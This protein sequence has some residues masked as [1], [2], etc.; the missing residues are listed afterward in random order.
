MLAQAGA[1]LRETTAL[2]TGDGTIPVDDTPVAEVLAGPDG[3]TRA[4]GIL[5]A[6]IEA[7]DS[8]LRR[9]ID[10]AAADA[11]LREV[12]GASQTDEEGSGAGIAAALAW[13]AARIAALVTG[14]GGVPDLRFLPQVLI[15]LGLALVAFILA[16]LGRGLKERFRREVL[17]ADHARER[18]EDPAVHLRAAESAL[19]GGRARDAIH[20]LYL[21]VI[22]SLSARELIRYD[23]A[24]TDRELLQRAAAIPQ[25]D[26]LRELIALN[27]R[28]WFGLRDPDPNEAER[29]RSL[30]ARV[31]G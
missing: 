27:E 8:A 18:A 20:E 11:R 30:A 25:A 12:L 31:A 21:F 2:R 7:A 5:D 14:L 1:L 22:G 16:T 24:L 15:G 17:V 4:L 28:A 19:A 13:I 3:A 9:P 10:P 6:Y 26:A 29:A 23:P